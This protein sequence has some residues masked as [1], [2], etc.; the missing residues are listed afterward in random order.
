MLIEWKE[1]EAMLMIYLS[2]IETAED[3]SL[4]EQIYYN[5]RKQMFFVANGILN[6]NFLAEDA[7]H[8][9]FLGIAK[10]ITLLQDMPESK[11]KA[12]VLTAAKNTAINMSKQEQRN[13]KYYVNLDEAE[14]EQLEDDTFNRH[15][16]KETQRTLVS[17]VSTLPDFQRDILMLRYSHNMNCT[18]I[19]VALG[20]KPSTVRK[21]LSRARHALRAGCRKEGVELED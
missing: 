7:V 6:D 13:S 17:V 3:R 15:M 11:M 4:F 10:Q 19:A 5:Y 12:Y 21:E 20:K 18:Q 8:E 1:R 2:I 16:Y 14:T 9:A